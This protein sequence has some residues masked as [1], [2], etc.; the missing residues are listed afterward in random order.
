MKRTLTFIVIAAAFLQ[1]TFVFAQDSRNRTVETIV[2]DVLAQM[3]AQDKAAFDSNMADLAMSAPKSIL[4]L[5]S[6]MHAP[7]EGIGN[8][9]LNT[10]SQALLPTFPTR[11]TPSTGRPSSRGSR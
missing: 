9:P 2:A 8:N 10:P 11:P 5:A 4:V 6:K 1:S 7:A 3:P